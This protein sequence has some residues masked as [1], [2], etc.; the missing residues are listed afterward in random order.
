MK[1]LYRSNS[2]RMVAGICG[3]LGHYFNVDST[4]IRLAFIVGLFISAFT[5]AFAYL[6]AIFII[7]NEREMR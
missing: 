4:I 5:L 7:P 3:G 1:R 6:L 2:D